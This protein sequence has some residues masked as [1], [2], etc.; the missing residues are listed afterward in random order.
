MRKRR[1]IQAGVTLI[2]LS[3]LCGVIVGIGQ[4]RFVKVKVSRMEAPDFE[5]IYETYQLQ[6]VK[7]PD[8]VSP[9]N[10]APGR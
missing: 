2:A 8:V 3:L 9:K 10:G 4:Y 7:S 1:L 6:R 5:T